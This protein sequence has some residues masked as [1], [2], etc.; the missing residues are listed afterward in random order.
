MA[1]STDP[2][3]FLSSCGDCSRQWHVEPDRHLVHIAN[4][5]K[6]VIALLSAVKH[7][8]MEVDSLLL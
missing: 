7:E 3:C 1:S 6:F 8:A 5:H 2:D 4:V